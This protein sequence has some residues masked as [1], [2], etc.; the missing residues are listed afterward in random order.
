M[1]RYAAAVSTC[2]RV[3][4]IGWYLTLSHDWIWFP[5]HWLAG[6]PLWPVRFMQT[7]FEISL[8]SIIIRI[9]GHMLTWKSPLSTVQRQAFGASVVPPTGKGPLF[10]RDSIGPIPLAPRG[11]LTKVA[12]CRLPHFHRLRS[13][14]SAATAAS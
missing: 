3:Q 5:Y 13:D 1:S 6:F 4:S 14:P 12:V 10:T 11:L 2:C 7:L 8:I 9:D